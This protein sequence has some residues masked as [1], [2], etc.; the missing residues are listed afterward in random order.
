MRDANKGF[1]NFFLSTAICSLLPFSAANSALVDAGNGLIN[2]TGQNITWTRDGLLFKTLA[3]SYSDGEA[4]FVSTVINS[5]AGTILDN[6]NHTLSADDFNTAT[7]E[8]SWWAAKAYVGYLNTINYAG[9]DNWR[10]PTT[11]VP[12]VS[13]DGSAS[14]ARGYHCASELG[15][16][17][18]KEL[19]G[20]RNELISAHHNAN[21]D[22]FSN[23]QDYSYWSGTEFSSSGRATS[24]WFFFTDDGWQTRFPKSI[25][26]PTTIVSAWAVRDGQA[27]IV[28]V[29]TAVWLFG[30]ALA[31][32]V[33][34]SRRKLDLGIM[35]SI[36]K[37]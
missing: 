30:S 29:P 3:D 36:K 12:D 15:N 11:P 18:W 13:C 21:Y 4:A 20:A 24:A 19:G 5:A 37:G 7:G 35:A 6:T 25:L 9:Y 14:Q 33:G 23:L 2:D 17:F 27:A 10:L 16:L 22:L 34:V 1:I 8:L 31:G 32:L 28:P 26:G